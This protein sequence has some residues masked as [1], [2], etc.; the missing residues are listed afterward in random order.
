MEFSHSVEVLS[1]VLA[2]TEGNQKLRQRDATD[3]GRG[4]G[5]D[6][7]GVIKEIRNKLF[8]KEEEQ[9]IRSWHHGSPNTGDHLRKGMDVRHRLAAGSV[10]HGVLVVI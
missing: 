3:L 4:R 8:E 5:G 10:L 6:T 7:S 9:W 2:V 1:A